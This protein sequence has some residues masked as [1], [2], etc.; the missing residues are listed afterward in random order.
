MK[1]FLARALIWLPAIM[2]ILFPAV[3]KLGHQLYSGGTIGARG[4]IGLE[5]LYLAFCA[6]AVFASIGV[7]LQSLRA[8]KVLDIVWVAVSLLLCLYF[9]GKGF[10]SGAALLHAT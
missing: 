8:K 3:V 2:G 1:I 4:A 5:L 9:L 6:A 7:G 10:Q